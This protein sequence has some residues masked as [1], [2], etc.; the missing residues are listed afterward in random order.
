[1]KKISPIP[2]VAVAH[3]LSI[4]AQAQQSPR[5]SILIESCKYVYHKGRLSVVAVV[6]ARDRQVLGSIPRAAYVFANLSEGRWGHCGRS[7]GQLAV[8]WWGLHVS[9]ARPGVVRRWARV[10]GHRC[11]WGDG[12]GC[13]AFTADR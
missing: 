9:S 11:W 12:A 1:M 2:W 10:C 7:M 3:A 6:H 5:I 4:A 8:V 13:G